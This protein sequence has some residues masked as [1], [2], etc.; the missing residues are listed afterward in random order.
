MVSNFDYKHRC[1]VEKNVPIALIL[2][3]RWQDVAESLGIERTSCLCSRPTS[4]WNK[5]NNKCAQQL[6]ELLPQIRHEKAIVNMTQICFVSLLQVF[7][8]ILRRLCVT[9]C[10]WSL[11]T[12][13][14]SG[15]W[16]L[17][18]LSHESSLQIIFVWSPFNYRVW[19][20][21]EKAAHVT[22]YVQVPEPEVTV[23]WV[24]LPT[25]LCSKSLLVSK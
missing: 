18:R 7:P 10:P 6:K 15:I 22:F 20:F 24:Y 25:F 4:L 16:M 8:F 9:N 12:C 19:M 3:S 14:L 11:R 23:L 2:P 13:F 5:L 21:H 17:F 1:L